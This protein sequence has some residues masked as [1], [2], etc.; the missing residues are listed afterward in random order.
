MCLGLMKG[1]VMRSSKEALSE[2]NR[3]LGVRRRCYTRWI[4]D[5]KLDS[6][7]ATDRMERMERAAEIV[8]RSCLLESELVQPPIQSTPPGPVDMQ[9]GDNE[10][11]EQW[12]RRLMVSHRRLEAGLPAEAQSQIPGPAKEIPY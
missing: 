3:E 6:V 11:R 8:E 9:R 1:T 5:G 10:T 12:D 2:I 4:S 7:E